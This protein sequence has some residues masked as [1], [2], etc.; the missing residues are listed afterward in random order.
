MEANLPRH[1]EQ[2]PRPKKA[3][4]G[5]KKDRDNKK[6][7]SSTQSQQY[8]L[9]NMPL[10][11][12]LM[13]IKDDPSLKWPEKM[14]GDRNKRYRNKYCRFHRDHGHVTDKCFDLK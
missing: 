3:R 14:K 11:Q 13:Q 6:A 2:G 9:L 7:S 10:E 4:T 5:E 1:P 12:V 8:T